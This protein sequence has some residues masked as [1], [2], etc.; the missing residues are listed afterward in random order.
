MY[1]IKE[2]NEAIWI[3]L[4]IGAFIGIAA[5]LVTEVLFAWAHGWF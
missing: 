4:V 5:T 2:L 3:N 1:T